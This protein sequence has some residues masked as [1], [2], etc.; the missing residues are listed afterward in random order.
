[1]N[2]LLVWTINITLHMI[3][4]IFKISIKTKINAM[5]N[6]ASAISIA[7]VSFS[8]Y[9]AAGHAAG[10]DDAMHYV[11]TG[12]IMQ[13]VV[14]IPAYFVAQLYYKTNTQNGCN[15]RKNRSR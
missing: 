10:A 2:I 4:K 11:I 6:V 15:G 12:I 8:S 9:S 14:G 7:T 3:E 1:M 13:A 5:V